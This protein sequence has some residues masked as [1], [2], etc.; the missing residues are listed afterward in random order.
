MESS[1]EAMESSERV[2]KQDGGSAP[3]QGAALQRAFDRHYVPLV[4]L[5]TLLTGG[6]N[7]A[8]DLVQEALIRTQK[9]LGTIHPD[10]VG[11]YLRKTVLNLWKTSARRQAFERKHPLD[12]AE[13]APD[14]QSRVVD[15]QI[16][17]AALRGLSA[18]QRACLVLRY[19]EDLNERETARALGC[20]VGAVKVHTSRGLRRLREELDDGS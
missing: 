6:V 19:F 5:A 8:E 15:R 3:P 18:R 9:T 7:N 2:D 1:E 10:A 16:V 17:L 11:P 14:P 4:R 12:A 13:V 20:S